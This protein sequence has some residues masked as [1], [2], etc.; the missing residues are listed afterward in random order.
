MTERCGCM[1]MGACRCIPGAMARMLQQ[2][3][4][5]K[6]AWEKWSIDPWGKGVSLSFTTLNIL[7][8][9]IRNHANTHTH[10]HTHTHTRTHTHKHPLPFTYNT[11]KEKLSGQIL[12]LLLSAFLK[13]NNFM[14]SPFPSVN[15]S[16]KHQLNF[17][18]KP[19]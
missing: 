5:E 10:T 13:L 8:F 2:V 17:V 6:S 4:Y 15:W 1:F 3:F 9:A 19:P 18:G 14:S 7:L 16:P 12:C 11:A